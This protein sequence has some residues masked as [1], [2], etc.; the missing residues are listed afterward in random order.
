MYRFDKEWARVDDTACVHPSAVIGSAPESR[1]WWK[2][3]LD[4]QY[5]GS[6]AFPAVLCRDVRV[7]PCARVDAGWKGYTRVG[8][9]SWVMAG[10][11][12]GHDCV[13]GK[14][15]EIG[16]NSVLCGHVTLG[17]NV[18]LGVGTMVRPGIT[19]G[20]GART[21]CGAVVVSDIPA[22]A[23]YVGNPARLLC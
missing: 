17:D 8:E 7:G 12:I 4:P 1:V 19:I 6:E 20:D 16:T 21:G 9:R 22:G 23:V 11:H 3:P 14:D 5:K 18:R 13:V 10:A 15:C 2:E